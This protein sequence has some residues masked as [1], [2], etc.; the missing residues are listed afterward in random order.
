MET[1]NRNRGRNLRFSY[2][3]GLMFYPQFI[4]RKMCQCLSFT[5]HTHPQ[6]TTHRTLCATRA[7]SNCSRKN[8][9][10]TCP[11]LRMPSTSW[12]KRTRTHSIRSRLS[13]TASVAVSAFDIANGYVD[14]RVPTTLQGV[15]AKV[16][17]FLHILL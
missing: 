8:S 6:P 5:Y 12:Q 10:R 1:R 9:T 16:S 4:R 2:S 7:S 11:H 14:Y 17:F 13:D 3:L 15:L